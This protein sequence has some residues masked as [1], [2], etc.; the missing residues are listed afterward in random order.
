MNDAEPVGVGWV[1]EQVIDAL[2]AAG[3][4][5]VPVSDVVPG[6]A[7]TL[8]ARVKYERDFLLGQA[9]GLARMKGGTHVCVAPHPCPICEA[10]HHG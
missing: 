9:V 10:L 4:A 3:Y 8:T 1:L 6:A 5:I 7:D 2:E